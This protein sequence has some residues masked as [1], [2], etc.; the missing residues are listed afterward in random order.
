MIRFG[1]NMIPYFGLVMMPCG[2]FPFPF[3]RVAKGL[4]VVGLKNAYTTVN[5]LFWSYIYIA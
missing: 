3:N 2:S 5:I 4:F 1:L